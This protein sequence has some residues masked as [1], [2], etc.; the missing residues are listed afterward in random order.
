MSQ[1]SSATLRLRSASSRPSTTQSARSRAA[2]AGEERTRSFVRPLTSSGETVVQP[3]L[4][5]SLF[6]AI[7]PT[8]NFILEGERGMSSCFNTNDNG[9]FSSQVG[10]L[11]MAIAG[12]GLPG[13]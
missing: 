9:N 5:P 12:S 3:A 10:L 2:G 11:S 13:L 6:P 8:I 7:P 1:G 4:R